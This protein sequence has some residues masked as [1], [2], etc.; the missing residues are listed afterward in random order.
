MLPSSSEIA[1]QADVASGDFCDA[2][3]KTPLKRGVALGMRRAQALPE[4]PMPEVVERVAKLEERFD[5]VTQRL[6]RIEV[7]LDSG[8]AE[9]KLSIARVED[10]SDARLADLKESMATGFAETKQ[11]ILRLDDRLESRFKWLMGGMAS[12]FLAILLAM[13]FGR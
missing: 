1:I 8:F 3:G 9:V 6:D 12:A 10:R 11:L 2:R 5:A 4:G 7:R 13:V